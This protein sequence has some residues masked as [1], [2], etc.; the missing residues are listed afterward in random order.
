VLAWACSKLGLQLGFGEDQATGDAD[1]QKFTEE[2]KALA[3]SN[4]GITHLEQIRARELD[5]FQ[6]AVAGY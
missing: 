5:R 4:V 6:Q 3:L 1:D 2:I